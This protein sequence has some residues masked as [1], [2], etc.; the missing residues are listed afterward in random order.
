MAEDKKESENKMLVKKYRKKPLIIEAIQFNCLNFDDIE[1]FINPNNDE[2][3]IILTYDNSE[4]EI[5]GL[6]PDILSKIFIETL[7]GTMIA[8]DGDYIIKGINSEFYPCKK[9]IFE[10]TY[11]LVE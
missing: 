1:L 3:N 4:E 10:K 11:D 7:E 2:N 6:K 5:D 8:I 9:E